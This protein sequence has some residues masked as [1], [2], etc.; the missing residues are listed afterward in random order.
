[1]IPEKNIEQYLF[2][3]IKDNLFD[4]MNILDALKEQGSYD[5]IVK[6]IYKM[7]KKEKIKQ[8]FD[9]KEKKIKLRSV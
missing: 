7:L 9:L 3:T 4:L 2:T 8:V 1:M 6:T 5:D